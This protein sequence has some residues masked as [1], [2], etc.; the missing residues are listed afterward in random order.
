MSFSSYQIGTPTVWRSDGSGILHSLA[1]TTAGINLCLSQQSIIDFKTEKKLKK[2]LTSQFNPVTGTINWWLRN[3]V[4]SLAHPYPDDNDDTALAISNLS[5]DEAR[6]FINKWL[7]TL[8]LCTS[9]NKTYYTWLHPT[10]KKIDAVVQLNI[11][12]ALL[13]HSHYKEN[14]WSWIAENYESEV[15]KSRFYTEEWLPA[16]WWLLWKKDLWSQLVSSNRNKELH[17]KITQICNNSIE[18]LPD[19]KLGNRWV[20]SIFFCHNTPTENSSQALPICADYVHN[21]P[22]RFFSSPE[23]TRLIKIRAEMS[24]NISTRN[25]CC[26]FALATFLLETKIDKEKSA[27]IIRINNA[28]NAISNG[29]YALSKQNLRGLII[30]DKLLKEG[31]YYWKEYKKNTNKRFIRN[32]GKTLALSYIA[33]MMPSRQRRQLWK[34][35]MVD[36]QLSQI[37]DDLHDWKDDKN[38][39]KNTQFTVFDNVTEV[40]S[41]AGK[42]IRHSLKLANRIRSKTLSWTVNNYSKSITDQYQPLLD[43]LEKKSIVE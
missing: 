36:A 40:A 15:K 13:K 21:K 23:L 41:E 1:S 31:T 43:S 17:K 18:M 2:T 8:K 7:K 12:R 9:S 10:W 22:I 30:P 32:L 19:D 14:L 37:S 20:K 39:N 38:N 29:K 16:Y 24:H 11:A 35:R 3:S 26:D 25:N 28:C 33:R 42:L 6:P 5:S 4:D 34:L 27:N